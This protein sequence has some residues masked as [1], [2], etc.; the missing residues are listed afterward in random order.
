M[1][2]LI[3]LDQ[4]NHKGLPL[5]TNPAI[6]CAGA[7]LMTLTCFSITTS[8]IPQKSFVFLSYTFAAFASRPKPSGADQHGYRA[9]ALRSGAVQPHAGDGGRRRHAERGG[10][11]PAAAPGAGEPRRH[12]ARRR[13]ICA[14]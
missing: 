11:A 1:A 5:Q 13:A 10:I 2:R 9:G 12:H 8:A 7:T 3:P 4:G 14:G 6:A